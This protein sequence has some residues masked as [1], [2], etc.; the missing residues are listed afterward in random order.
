VYVLTL[1]FKVLSLPI[2]LGRP[3][4][5]VVPVL[6]FEMY[7]AG[8]YTQLNALGVVVVVLV[9]AVSLLVRRVSRRFG[10]EEVR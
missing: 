10:M 2:L 4:T 3:G 5:E 8:E 6:I 1:T 7:E 9:T